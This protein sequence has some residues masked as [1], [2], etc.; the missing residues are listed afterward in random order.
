MA[1]INRPEWETFGP[2][3]SLN[4]D[5]AVIKAMEADTFG[6]ATGLVNS[7]LDPVAEAAGQSVADA[8]GR[9]EGDHR[10]RRT[11]DE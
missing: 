9:H 4:P 3:D 2:P 5:Q 1:S 6:H 10:G 8:S 7:A 11:S